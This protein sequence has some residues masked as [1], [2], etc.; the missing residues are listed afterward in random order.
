MKRVNL[1]TE[2]KAVIVAAMMKFRFLAALMMAAAVFASCDP[3]DDP[4]P[5]NPSGEGDEMYYDPD[6]T[7]VRNI[8]L[9]NVRIKFRHRDPDPDMDDKN[10]LVIEGEAMVCKG[11]I[12]MKDTH[13]AR[14]FA[15]EGYSRHFI[16]V[17]NL[18][19]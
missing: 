18:H 7:S 2:S 13:D 19:C 1:K 11:R 6:D 5:D 9:R 10:R 4:D 12:Y 17:L 14:W 16:G 8:A 15:T 3:T